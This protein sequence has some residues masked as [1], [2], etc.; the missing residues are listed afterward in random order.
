LFYTLV[1]KQVGFF[2]FFFPDSFQTL[3][4]KKKKKES[5]KGKKGKNIR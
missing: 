1:K 2:L 5:L 3:R 4:A